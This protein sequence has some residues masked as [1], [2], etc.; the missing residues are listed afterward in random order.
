MN[1]ATLEATNASFRTN[2]GHTQETDE[3]AGAPWFGPYTMEEVHRDLDQAEAEEEAGLGISH[4]DFMKEM[5]DF[6]MA[7]L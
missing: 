7:P 2:I 6:I 3:W 5:R 1:T 4:E